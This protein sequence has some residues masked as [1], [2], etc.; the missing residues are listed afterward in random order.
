MSG[1]D[2]IFSATEQKYN[3]PPGI[4]KATAQV[5]TH[6]NPKAVSPQGAE[7]LMQLLPST[8]QGLGVDPYDVPHAIDGAGR[9]W[10]QNLKASGGDIDRAAMMYHGG[11]D[12]RQWGPKTHA[13]PGNSRRRWDRLKRLHN[14][15][16]IHLKPLCLA[17]LKARQRRPTREGVIHLKRP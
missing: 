4:L 3:L 8:A 11:N 17:D 2:P 9:L 16:P 6:F 14:L 12:T 13:Y 10:A 15:P 5:E 1:F 7:G